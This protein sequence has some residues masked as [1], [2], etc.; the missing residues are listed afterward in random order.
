MSRNKRRRPSDQPREWTPFE[1]KSH[2]NKMTH[3]RNNLYAVTAQDFGPVLHLAITP[4]DGRVTV[5]NLDDMQRIKVE[6]GGGEDREAMQIFPAAS[7]AI[8][9]PGAFHLWV[10]KPGFTLPPVFRRA[11]NWRPKS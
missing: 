2:A 9:A 7:R 6:L 8:H 5:Q 11:G 4:L 3:F 1:E 10:L